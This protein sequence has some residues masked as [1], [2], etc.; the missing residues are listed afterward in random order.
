MAKSNHP[1]YGV[2]RNISQKCNNPNH[3]QYRNYGAVGVRLCTEWDEDFWAFVEDMGERPHGYILTRIDV[4][5]DYSRDNCEWSNPNLK[6]TPRGV[7]YTVKNALPLQERSYSDDWR[8][9]ST[10][11]GACADVI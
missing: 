2:Y 3:P 5:E 7:S 1:L 9:D 6:T 10:Y 8:P 4:T 11:R